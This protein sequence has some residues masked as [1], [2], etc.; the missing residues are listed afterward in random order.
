[1]ALPRWAS[2]QA[3]DESP[4]DLWRRGGQKHFCKSYKILEPGTFDLQMT[5]HN[6]PQLGI[7]SPGTPAPEKPTSQ[8]SDARRPG[9][10][11]SLEAKFI[12]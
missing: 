7:S 12:F 2:K 6:C 3:S 1:M 8:T 4:A 10:E 11:P 9:Q 5:R